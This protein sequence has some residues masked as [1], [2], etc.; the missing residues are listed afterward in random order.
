M[1]SSAYRCGGSAGWAFRS[2][3]S[4]AL[5]PV[6][7]RHVNHTASTNALHSRRRGLRKPYNEPMPSATPIEQLAEKVDLLLVRH[8]ELQRTNELL[9]QQLQ[10][11]THERDALRQRLGTARARIDALLERLPDLRDLHDAA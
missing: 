5:L 4:A 10:S 2:A 7:L 1:H 9:M 11:V 6:E 8:E 3:R